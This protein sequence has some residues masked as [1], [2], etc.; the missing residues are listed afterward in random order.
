MIDSSTPFYSHSVVRTVCLRKAVRW[1]TVLALLGLFPLLLSVVLLPAQALHGLGLALF[2]FFLFCLL[3]GLLPYKRLAKKQLHPDALYIE[4]SRNNWDK[5]HKSPQG[6]QGQGTLENDSDCLV[7]AVNGQIK[8]RL[9]LRDI[10]SLHYI[11][12]SLSD[13]GIEIVLTNSNDTTTRL[14]FPYFT[15]ASSDELETH[16]NDIMHP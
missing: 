14:F 3:W 7:Y 4:S 10:I 2:A 16:L 13:Y 9:P 5:E 11:T 15:Q 8:Q 12:R 1:G 6:H